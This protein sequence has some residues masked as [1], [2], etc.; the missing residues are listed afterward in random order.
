MNMPEIW[1]NFQSSA[2]IF[3]QNDKN[4]KEKNKIKQK[5]HFSSNISLLYY[6][7]YTESILIT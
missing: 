4:K 5:T 7:K 2:D 1:I 6:D 3:D